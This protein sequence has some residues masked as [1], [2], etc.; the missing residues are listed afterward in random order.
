MDEKPLEEVCEDTP[1][2]EYGETE[3][4][5][6][7]IGYIGAAVLLLVIAMVLLFIFVKYIAP[8]I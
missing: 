8:A 7:I 5:D 1:L 6:A 4:P 2:S 3:R